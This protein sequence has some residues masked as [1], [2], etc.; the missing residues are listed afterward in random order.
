MQALRTVPTSHPLP[1]RHSGVEKRLGSSIETLDAF[2]TRQPS[3]TQ[4]GLRRAQRHTGGGLRRARRAA[5]A[6]RT[7]AAPPDNLHCPLA[8]RRDLRLRNECVCHNSPLSSESGTLAAGDMVEV[9]LG[10]HTGEREL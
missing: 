7:N 9:D 4:V 6:R 8:L 3:G 10:C 1:L 2:L 5:R